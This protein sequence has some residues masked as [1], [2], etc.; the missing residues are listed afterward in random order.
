MKKPCFTAAVPV[1][2]LMLMMSSANLHAAELRILAGGGMA[3]VFAELKPAFERASGHRLDIVF[4]T[5]P[6]L[7]KEATSGAP[8]DAGVVPVDL[9]KDAAA[10]ARFASAPTTDVARVG[11]GVAVRAGAGKP[12]ISTADAFKQT[13]LKA[14]SVAF[15]PASAAGAQILRVFERLG[16]AEAMKAKTRVQTAPAQIAEAVAKG[17]AE[18][19][20]FLTTVLIAPG[21]DLAGPFP[22]ELQQDLVYTAAVAASS[23][24]AEAAKAFL[25]YLKTPEAV[26]IIKARGMTPG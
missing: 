23:K 19:G 13:M 20:L 16:I 8:F 6:N 18:L 25:D 21:V 15:I 4:G 14:Q 12:D 17:D 26:A 1:L 24:D 7:I 10:R 22:G 3:P 5:T 2:G 11:Y 9:M